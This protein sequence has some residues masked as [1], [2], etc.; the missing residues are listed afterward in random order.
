MREA[1][2]RRHT[3]RSRFGYL[4]GNIPCISWIRPRPYMLDSHW[5][6]NHVKS[7]SCPPTVNYDYPDGACVQLPNRKENKT[8]YKQNAPKA[9]L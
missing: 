3:E 2:G 4:M 9:S 6:I 1:L 5:V 8:T 7:V